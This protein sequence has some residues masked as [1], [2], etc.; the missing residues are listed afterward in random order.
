MNYESFPVLYIVCLVLCVLLSVMPVLDSLPMFYVSAGISCLHVPCSNCQACVVMS[1]F[2][3]VSCF[4]V[5][6]PVLCAVCSHWFP[7][8]LLPFCVFKSSV[9]LCSV[10]GYLFVWLHVSVSFSFSCLR[11]F[12]QAPVQVHVL[13]ISCYSCSYFCSGHAHVTV[14]MF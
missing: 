12:S 4:I 8:R 1:M 9:F 3:A 11:F 14:F 5:I 13:F 2:H 6:N 7:I 10:L